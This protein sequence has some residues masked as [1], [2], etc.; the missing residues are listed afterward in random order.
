[1]IVRIWGHLQGGVISHRQRRVNVTPRAGAA[2]RD[3]ITEAGWGRVR[4][5]NPPMIAAGDER[6]Q[7]LLY[8][9]GLQL[10]FVAGSSSSEVTIFGHVNIIGPQIKPF[11]VRAARCLWL[12]RCSRQ[13]YVTPIM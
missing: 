5:A 3:G 13:A 9:P 4:E 7:F 8:A 12:W 11:H 6:A 1:M 10:P 2:T